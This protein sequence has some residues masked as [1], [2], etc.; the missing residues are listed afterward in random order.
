M[1]KLDSLARFNKKM[2]SN[3]LRAICSSGFNCD[4]DDGS[5]VGSIMSLVNGVE[6]N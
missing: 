5:T 6:Q 4:K 3:E 2:A 1:I